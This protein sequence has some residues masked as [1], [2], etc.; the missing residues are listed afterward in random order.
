VGDAEV[1]KVRIEQWISSV[2]LLVGLAGTILAAREIFKHPDKRSFWGSPKQAFWDR[3]GLLMI[4]SAFLL[5]L[6]ALWS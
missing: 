4:G 6:V 5:Q 1:R 2:A 3:I